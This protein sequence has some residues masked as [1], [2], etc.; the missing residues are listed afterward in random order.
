[1]P[2]K[3]RSPAAF[4]H[5]VINPEVLEAMWRVVDAARFAICPGRNQTR[6]EALEFLA[7]QEKMFRRSIGFF[8][9][10]VD[11]VETVLRGTS[12]KHPYILQLEDD[13]RNWLRTHAK[14]PL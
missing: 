1:M 11:E 9:G 3:K 2:P 10:P 8:H 12:T 5:P 13:D 14:E 6:D 4:A 7:D